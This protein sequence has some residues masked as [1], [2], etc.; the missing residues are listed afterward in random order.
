M[1]DEK[2]GTAPG[3]TKRDELAA[4]FMQGMLAG[5]ATLEAGSSTGS[6]Q[7]QGA[8]QQVALRAY[9]FADGV[10]AARAD[11]AR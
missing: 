9:R 6:L 7:N 8:A 10:L 1:A 2:K 5:N 3:W 4:M 11:S